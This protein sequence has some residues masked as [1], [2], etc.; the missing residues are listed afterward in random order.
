MKKRKG[1]NEKEKS[2][3]TR[4]DVSTC[5]P[6]NST[7]LTKTSNIQSHGEFQITEIT[8]KKEDEDK[9]ELIDPAL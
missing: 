7:L 9:F 8:V 2:I 4:L 6:G 1:R 3:N 5:S